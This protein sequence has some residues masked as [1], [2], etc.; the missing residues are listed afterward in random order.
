MP[1][2]NSGRARGKPRTGKVKPAGAQAVPRQTLRRSTPARPESLEALA[3]LTRKDLMDLARRAGL[4]GRS[5]LKKEELARALWAPLKK[6][7]PQ[8][9]PPA[10]PGP[11]QWESAPLPEAYGKERLV[12]MPV[13]PHWVHAYWEMGPHSAPESRSE[14]EKKGEPTRRV[15]RVYD[16]T[17]IDFDGTNANSSFDIEITPQAQNWYINLWS[18]GKSLCAELGMLYRDG[19]F[20][21]RV[22]SNVI[23]TPPTWAS[24]NTEERWIR[25]ESGQAGHFPLPAFASSEVVE[26]IPRPGSRQLSGLPVVKEVEGTQRPQESLRAEEYRRFLE[27]TRRLE[28]LERDG[29]SPPPLTPSPMEGFVRGFDAGLS[30]GELLKKRQRAKRSP[31]RAWQDPSPQTKWARASD[32]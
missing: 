15:L 31:G 14:D 17:S 1:R 32:V 13:D 2:R 29:F 7:A 22:R 24:Q 26:S 23:Q 5:R 4:R 9:E 16:V 6:P 20:S 28:I 21:P 3:R 27:E 19:V 10:S 25:V 12:L 8:T 11:P 30:S 18:P